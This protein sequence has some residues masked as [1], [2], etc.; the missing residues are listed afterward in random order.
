MKK[1]ITLGT[2]ITISIIIMQ[3]VVIVVLALMVVSDVAKGTREMALNNM[4][5]ITQERAQIVEN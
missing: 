2:K 5:A 3:I 1:Q 4:E